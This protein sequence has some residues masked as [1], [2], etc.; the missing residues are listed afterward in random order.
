MI[1][2]HQRHIR[3]T[4]RR[5]DDIRWHN[6]IFIT[7]SIIMSTYRNEAKYHAVPHSNIRLD[8]IVE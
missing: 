2:M 3:Q 7:W 5:T 4:N 8:I 1:T 6:L